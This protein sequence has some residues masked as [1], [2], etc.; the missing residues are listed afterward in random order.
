MLA[1]LTISRHFYGHTKG[2]T[3]GQT[4]GQTYGHGILYR[5]VTLN[6]NLVS[7][8]YWYNYICE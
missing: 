3:N 5:L 4:N 6:S 2:Q 8:N 7:Y 1:H